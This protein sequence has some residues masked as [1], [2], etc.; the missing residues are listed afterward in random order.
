VAVLDDVLDY[1]SYG[2]NTVLYATDKDAPSGDIEIDVWQGGKSYDIQKL[3]ASSQYLLNLTQY[4]GDWY[5]AAGSTVGDKVYVYKDPVGQLQN[6]PDLPL[7]PVY[8]LK[9]DQP[10]YLEFSNNAQFIVAEGGSSFAV[11]DAENEKGYAYSVTTPVAAGQH[12]SWM[13]GD[14]LTLAAGGHVIVFDYD[15]ANQQTLELAVAGALPFFDQSY[16]W[17]YVLA[18]GTDQT[19]APFSLTSTALR[20]PL[21]Q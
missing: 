10:D 21:D 3:P 13:D 2:N 9:V 15:D 8:I 11:Y 16:K 12:A 14:R 19:V 7:V 6:Q 5:I 20:T 1:K 17:L 18:P 4:S